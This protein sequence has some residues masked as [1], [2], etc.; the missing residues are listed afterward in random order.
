MAKTYEV[1]VF[2]TVTQKYE[3]VSVSKEVYHAYKRTGWNI[4]DNNESFY[5][6]EIQLSSLIGGEDGAYDNF[7]EF[8]DDS[9]NPELLFAQQ[10]QIE[11]LYAAINKLC[12]SDRELIIAIYFE[13]MTERSYASKSGIPTMTVHDRKIRALKRLKDFLR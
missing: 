13:G 4:K 9:Q 8:I 7:S 1:T 5:A 11:E 6:H 10:E 3:K 12:N 2:N